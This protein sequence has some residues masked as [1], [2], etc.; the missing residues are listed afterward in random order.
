[1]LNYIKFQNSIAIIQ[2]LVLS[3]AE[4]DIRYQKKMLVA[5]VYKVVSSA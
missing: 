3:K 4:S 5:V 2:Y 1:M